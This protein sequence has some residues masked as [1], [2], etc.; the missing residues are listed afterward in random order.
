MRTQDKN[1]N[2]RIDNLK[3]GT[4]VYVKKEGILKKL[5]PK[6]GGPY[7]VVKCTE[8][9]NYVLMDP[10]GAILEGS[11][12]LH[13]LKLTNIDDIDFHNNKFV[14]VK[15]VLDH[16]RTDAGITEYLVIWSNDGESWVKESDFNAKGCIR[17]YH[18]RKDPYSRLR[19]RRKISK[20]M[21]ILGLKLKEVQADLPKIKIKHLQNQKKALVDLRKAWRLTY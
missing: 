9:N 20:R 3:P 8:N 15:S 14:E 16:R 17:E 12:P 11:V 19:G 21:I 18:N 7:E 2:V 5:E 13:K 10:T 6:Y 1:S 4:I